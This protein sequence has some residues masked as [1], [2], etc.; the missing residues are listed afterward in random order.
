M[1]MFVQPPIPRRAALSGILASALLPVAVRAA[2]P[3]YD[4]VVAPPERTA[5]PAGR[6]FPDLDA[7]L[8]AAPA[9]ARR[10]YRI[11]IARGDWTGQFVIDRPHVE[12]VGE[13]RA[14]T[15]LCFTAASGLI[16]PDGRPYGTF[17]TAV[18]KVTAPG[19][20]ARSLTID[21]RFDGTAE[22]RKTGPRLLSD[23]PAGPQAIALAL[24]EGS[25]GAQLDRVDIHSHQDSLFVDAGSSRF[26][27]C[28]ISG[29]YDFIFG[30]GSALF[31]RCEI[32]S[33]LRPDPAQVTGYVVAPSTLAERAVG[34]LLHRCRLTRESGVADGSVFLG[35]PW[36]PSKRFDDGRYGDPMAVGM[37]AC[38]D[39]WMDAHIAPAGWTEMW[40][41]DR[42][43][44][45][46]HMLQPEEAR[47]SEYRSSGPGAPQAGIKRRGALLTAA[48]AQNLLRQI[49]RTRQG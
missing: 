49:A 44:N 7:A 20:S 45:N 26:S 24:I 40:F 2:A 34:L 19:F 4:A 42:A 28:L 25:D 12:L 8:K 21:N 35:R 3:S 1:T 27:D 11:W 23:A 37:A 32:R 36:R 43:G 31:E 41:T 38:L 14:A 10:P 6:R 22:M 33:R 5:L 18:V 16:A 13:D 29:S 15:R 48:D 30:A 17:R 47:F 46:R 39:C 9:D